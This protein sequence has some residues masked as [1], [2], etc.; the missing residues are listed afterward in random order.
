[1]TTKN[2]NEAIRKYV[3]HLA[4]DF[5]FFCQELWEDIGLP[6]LAEHQRQMSRWL[7][8]GPRRRGIRAF[9]GASKTWVTLAYCIWR[10][11]TNPNERVLLVSK[12][13]KHSKDSLF[14]VRRWISQVQWL[15]HLAPDK[16]GG[17]RDS[18]TKFDVGPSDND[19]IPSFT[20]A[21]IGGQI[22][23]LRSTCVIGDDCETGENTLTLE[24]R[25]RLRHQ[26]TEF[27]NIIIPGC[28]IIFLGTPHHPESLYDKLADSGYSFQSWPARYPTDGEDIPDLADDLVEAMNSGEVKPGDPVWGSRF[29]DQE[30]LERE[31]SEGRST[32][33]MQ[34]MMLTHLGTGL[35]CPL[36]LKD[37]MVFPVM[38][39]KAPMTIAWGTTN[40]RG[41]TTRL[42]E[43]TSY[44]LGTDGFYAPIFYDDDWANY[45]GTKMWIDPS[46]A[47]KDLTGYAIV[48]H[49]NGY[50][51]VKAVGG[52]EGGYTNTTLEG[53]AMQARL[54]NVREIYCEDN[55]GQGMFLNLFQPVLARHFAP[56]E[57]D[58]YPEGW[59]ATLEG[60]RVHG[61]KE[62]R[63]IQALEPVM[64]QHRCLLDPSV[65]ENQELQ[66]QLTRITR[67]RNCLRHDD[68]VES[69]AMC[70]KMWE[71]TM[72]SDPEI[73][74]ARRRE[75]V[76][77]DKVNSHYAAMGLST[78]GK[79]RWF[80]HHTQ[81]G[82]NG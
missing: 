64:I 23:G 39:D 82:P 40:D 69:L 78:L 21:S 50:L 59:G 28:D 5:E 25:D 45:T 77:I 44:G 22:V 14:M 68:M 66:A 7:Q 16:R 37:F 35:D 38:R 27:D 48:S 65:A 41:G 17:Q 67:D 70:V 51:H 31:A 18:A 30:L 8:F 1:M 24:Q 52:L 6:M 56:V 72:R 32:Y 11:F 26:V 34:Y 10:L 49:L 57:D 62:I 79:N 58:E 46:G 33:A 74:A 29:T 63:I 55:F 9:R 20:A 4:R 75:Q 71:D 61:Q 76:M 13:E 2:D 47:G 73:G 43:V 53:L 36:K 15:Q 3:E 81:K 80:E 60:Y 54:H 19:R 12:S 42:E